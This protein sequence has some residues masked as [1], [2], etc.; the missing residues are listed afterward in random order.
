MTTLPMF[1]AAQAPTPPP[2][3]P[4]PAPAPNPADTP[5]IRVG[6]T[7]YAD[8][9]FAQSP[10]ITDADGNTVHAN[11]FNVG[12]SYINITGNL[13]RIVN[14]RITPDISRETGT[15][16]SLNG[17]LVFRIKYAFMQFNL[18]DWAG[19]GSWTRLGIQ[20]TPIV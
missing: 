17:S 6:A 12:R 3:T 8:Y 19:A 2:A 11:A 4:P 9:T 5:N 13:S 16:S 15:G 18:D 14:F 10:E 20:Q 7:I 1:V